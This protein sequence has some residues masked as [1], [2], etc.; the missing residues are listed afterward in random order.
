MPMMLVKSR[1]RH[2]EARLG[3]SQFVAGDNSDRLPTPHGL[4]QL[5]PDTTHDST[6][7]GHD[8]SLFICISLNHTGIHLAHNLSSRPFANG[9]NLQACA[10]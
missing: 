5:R 4:A 7:E 8:G 2:Q 1:Q 10:L 9:F 3:I 6:Y